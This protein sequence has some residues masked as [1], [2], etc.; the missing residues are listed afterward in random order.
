[1]SSIAGFTGKYRF[2]SNFFIE[3]DGSHVEGEYQAAKCTNAKDRD[4]I[5][6][7]SPGESKRYGRR[8]ELR[9]DWEDVKIEIMMDLVFKK[10]ADHPE[11]KLKLLNTGNFFLAEDNWWGDTFWGRCNGVGDNHLGK[12]LM[13]VR[14]G[15]EPKRKLLCLF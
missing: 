10:F 7:M 11:L 15:W 4:K 2:L 9:P 5:L 8:V 13:I 1:M 12:I 6:T 3:P 14:A